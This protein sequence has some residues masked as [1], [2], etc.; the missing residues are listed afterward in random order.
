MALKSVPA[1]CLFCLLVS[2]P[3]SARG[4]SE[5]VHTSFKAGPGYACDDEICF[6]VSFH[7][8]RPPRGIR[9]FPDGG[10]PRIVA[11]GLFLVRGNKESFSVERKLIEERISQSAIYRYSREFFEGREPCE[12]FDMNVTNRLIRE[13][14]PGSIGLPSPLEYCRKSTAEYREDLIKKNG[15]FLYRKAI[16]RFLDPTVQE[17]SELLKQMEEYEKSLEGLARSE[18]RLYSE[19]TKQEL[20][21]RGGIL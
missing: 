7:L 20:R 15:D 10:I 6:L 14:G 3:A 12:D 13:A 8:Y 21:K 2:T 5:E 19:D 18:Y 16:I 4:F 9:R 17:A 11:E 1:M